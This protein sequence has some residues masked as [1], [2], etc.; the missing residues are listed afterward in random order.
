MTSR[1]SGIT[2]SNLKLAPALIEQGGTRGKIV[3]EGF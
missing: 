2:A 1:M 3:L